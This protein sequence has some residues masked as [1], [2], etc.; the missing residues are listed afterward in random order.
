MATLGDGSMAILW[1]AP[2]RVYSSDVDYEYRQDSDLLYLTGVEQPETILVLL[3]GSRSSQGGVV[4]LALQPRLEHY[5]GRFLSI[6]EARAKTG[7][8]TVFFTTRIRRRSCHRCSTAGPYGLS[9][10]GPRNRPITRSS[11]ARWTKATARL[12]LRLE[13]PPAIRTNR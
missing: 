12:A 3:P 5:V 10:R 6:E 13:S 7:I 9:G 4:H 2:H 1:S 8:D 11:S